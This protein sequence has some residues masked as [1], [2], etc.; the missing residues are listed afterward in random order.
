MSNEKL[1]KTVESIKKG[2]LKKARKTIESVLKEKV[3][4]ALLKKRQ[5]LAK[6]LVR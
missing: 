3:R 1:V 4:N 2:N 5:E 6:N